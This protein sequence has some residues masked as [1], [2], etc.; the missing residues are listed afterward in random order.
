M[1]RSLVRSVF[2][3]VLIAAALVFKGTTVDA[4]GDLGRATWAS[5]ADLQSADTVRR[6]VSAALAG[7]FDTLVVPASIFP[8][9]LPA[10]DGVAEAIAQAHARG[11][12]VQAAIEVNRVAGADEVPG[13]RTHV[14]YEH[15]EW[16]MIPRALAPEVLSLDARSPDYVGRLARWTRANAPR[17]NGLYVSPLYPEAAAYVA[18]AV[19]QFVSQYMVDGIELNEAEY[20][21]EDFDYSRFAMDRFRADLRPRLTAA[22]RKRM[23]GI[24]PLDPFAYADEYGEEWQRFRRASLTALVTRVRTAAKSVRRQVVVSARLAG[25]PVGALRDHLQDWQTW[26]DNGFVDAIARRAGTTGTIA[27][28]RAARDMLPIVSSLRIDDRGAGEAPLLR[29]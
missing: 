17:V 13:L 24:E 5:A 22:E 10:F 21:G 15:P 8:S 1:S 14:A 20:P 19:Q 18:A 16:L 4:A 29:P 28:S 23:D 11:L 9:T 26:I 2:Y 6:A 7:G 25:D 27:A 12:R 3:A